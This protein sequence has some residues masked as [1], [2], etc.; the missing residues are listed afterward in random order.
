MPTL[1]AEADLKE[2]IELSKVV[3][4]PVQTTAAR[5]RKDSSS[6][7]SRT[8][9]RPQESHVSTQASEF[10]IEW[11]TPSKCKVSGTGPL[12]WHEQALCDQRRTRSHLPH[13][14]TRSLTSQ[15]ASRELD[16]SGDPSLLIFGA[17]GSFLAST[18][19]GETSRG[20]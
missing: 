8:N 13:L 1:K 19:T 18:S 20:F 2:A 17:A 3:C 4:A 15:V 9:P 10:V 11:A 5:E 12:R 7:V 16:I 6:A 14:L